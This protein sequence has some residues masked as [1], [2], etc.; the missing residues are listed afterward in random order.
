MMDMSLHVHVHRPPREAELLRTF[1]EW[2]S[3]QVHLTLGPEMPAAP[4]YHILVAG[5]PTRAQ[6]EASA[7]LRAV[8][9]P[10]A[11]IPEETLALLREFPGIQLHNLHHNAAPTAETAL[12]LLLAA[13]KHIVPFDKA[14]RTGDWTPRYT[15][16]PAILLEGKTVLVLGYGAIG[17]RVGR[18]C[19]ALGM[20]VLAVRSHPLPVDDFAEMY[21]LADLP[22]LLPQAHVV[23]VTLPLT[24][25]TRGLLNETALQSLPQDS[26]L[27][28]VGRGPVVD[29]DALYRAL[30]EGP[31]AA[32]GL[33]VWYRYPENR[34]SR[35]CTYPSTKPI[36]E[37]ENVVLSPHRGGSVRESEHL[38][39][40]ALAEMLNAAVRGEA[41]PNRVNIQ[42]G[43]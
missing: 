5:R 29:E 15:P 36:Y 16:T 31:L 3:P 6:L 40:R 13:A 37:L 34:A 42:H 43:Y 14:L 26:I 39:L 30:C 11:G 1:R 32:A 9:V 23:V 28:N 41:M 38:R 27:V 12:A 22:A 19:H 7:N 4:A 8:I 2:L 25:V 10:W 18:Y 21:T 33:D 20:R 24:D 35:T 17:R